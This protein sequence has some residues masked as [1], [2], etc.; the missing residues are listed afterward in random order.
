[1]NLLKGIRI[2]QVG[3]M[4]CE[5]DCGAGWRN[6]LK[7]KLKH[8]GIKWFDPV[9]K[10]F[11]KDIQESGEYQTKLKKWREDGNYE[12]LAKHMKEIRSYD[13]SMVDKSDAIIFFY[14]VNKPTCG[15]WEELF[16]ANSIKRPI[17]VIANQG[18][19]TLPLW[20]FG[21]IPHKYFH[22]SLDKVVEI[23]NSIDRG[24]KEVDSNRWRL[25]K[26]EY[27]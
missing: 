12:K 16:H 13:L 19:K 22:D 7:E 14:D 1:M 4:E 6:E 24:D 18:I 15:S 9:N 23:I 17:F 27:R 5:K 10:V 11:V 2:Y 3:P 8:V 26:K 21:T 25:L 20:L